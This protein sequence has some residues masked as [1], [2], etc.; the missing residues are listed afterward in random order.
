MRNRMCL[1]DEE[2]KREYTLDDRGNL[3][4]PYQAADEKFDFDIFIK[5]S[6]SLM[7]V[8]KEIHISFDKINDYTIGLYITSRNAGILMPPLH[9]ISAYHTE[10]IMQFSF[11]SGVS[12]S[13]Y[14]EAK[15]MVKE[16]RK[17]IKTE[18]PD[19]II[20]REINCDKFGIYFD[21]N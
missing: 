4:S 19:I 3:C 5:R 16:L 13:G 18:Y 21:K 9:N 2:L 17:K 6:K 10:C 15:R 1:T 7:C 20:H 12:D 14:Q 8:I 11:R